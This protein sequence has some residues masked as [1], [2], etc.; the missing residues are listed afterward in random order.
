M[1]LLAD[2]RL[3]LGHRG[4]AVAGVVACAIWVVWS[5]RLGSQQK[6][7]AAQASAG[8]SGGNALEGS[9]ESA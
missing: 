2:V 1:L 5:L 3:H 9:K 6:L 7:L 4:V 8:S